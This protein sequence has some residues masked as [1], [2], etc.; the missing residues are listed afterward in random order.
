MTR[1]IPYVHSGRLTGSY[2]EY[3]VDPPKFLAR[4]RAR[5][6]E[7]FRFRIGH[8]HL[9][10]LE[11][12][13]W[14][15]HVLHKNH[16]NYIKSLAYRKLR[17]LLG[18][19]L[20]TSD[21]GAWKRQRQVIGPAFRRERI[22]DYFALMTDFTERMLVRWR[23]HDRINLNDEMR[24]ITLQIVTKTLLGVESQRSLDIIRH[25]LPLALRYVLDRVSSPL[26][27]PTYLPT[28]KNLRFRAAMR[29][30]HGLMQEIVSSRGA[31]EANDVLSSLLNGIHTIEPDAKAQPRTL[32]EQVLTLFVAG[33]ETSAIA[34]CWTM[35]LLGRHPQVLAKLRS[36][37]RS[38]LRREPPS[39][40][41]LA[42]LP[43][44]AQVLKESLRLMPPIWLMARESLGTDQLGKHKIL[45][46]DILT[47]C[48]YLMHR[49]E[50][51][52]SEPGRFYPE[53]FDS[54]RGAD[55]AP[56]TYFPFG[57]GPRLC[58]GNNFAMLELQLL[59]TRIVQCYDF[60][61]ET[62]HHPGVEFSLSLRP[63]NE[64]WIRLRPV[65][66]RAISSTFESTRMH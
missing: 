44:T 59:L 3:V 34:L 10:Y 26:P 20:L 46:G 29:D 7:L 31:A 2:R 15:Q 48:P 25:Q 40:E 27:L 63:R 41:E 55:I 66:T 1:T 42:A 4:Q 50:L 43:Y 45:P 22:R 6:G 8:R 11:R 28:P 17:L 14:V 62:T 52:W 47:I 13:E 30:M 32:R 18:E 21:G 65:D 53:R 64:I 51:Y 12:A 5:H 19:G 16:A 57:G 58:I 61:L 36:E 60:E 49:S 56:Y 35:H 54:N 38:N 33:H 37:V 24:H 39:M 23:G 9:I